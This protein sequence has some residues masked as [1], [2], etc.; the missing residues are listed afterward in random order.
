MAKETEPITYRVSP[1]VDVE[2][3]KLAQV[4]G[5]VDRALRALFELRG[6]RMSKAE[7]VKEALAESDL[8]AQ[9]TERDDIEY[10]HHE[11]L[12]RGEHVVNA[13]FKEPILKPKDKQKGK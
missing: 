4:Y 10:G 5:G 3:R 11:S 7:K 1:E 13:R 8:T 12:P 2:L 6:K 9:V